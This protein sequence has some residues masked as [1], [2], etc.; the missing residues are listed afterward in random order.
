[1]SDD[2]QPKCDACEKPAVIM[3]KVTHKTRKRLR[4]F[5]IYGCAHHY[6][7]QLFAASRQYGR[8]NVVAMQAE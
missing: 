7:G 2:V 1:M 6:G 5:T 8:S 3:L 4:R